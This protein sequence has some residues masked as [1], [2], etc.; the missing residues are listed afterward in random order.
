[1]KRPLTL[2][3][4]VYLFALFVSMQLDP[5]P[6]MIISIILFL[7]AIV[8]FLLRKRMLTKIYIV[9][10]LTSAMAFLVYD[11]SYVCRVKPKLLNESVTTK[12]S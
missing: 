12:V 11:V 3:G 1:M 5:F 2:V 6:N 8:L 10:A 9:A 7:F 4:F